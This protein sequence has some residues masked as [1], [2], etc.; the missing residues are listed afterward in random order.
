MD[1]TWAADGAAHAGAARLRRERRRRAYLRYARMSVA[2]ALAEATHRTAPRCQKTARARGEERDELYDAKG[3]M[4]PPP[5]RPT[6]LVEVRPQGR[7]QR[8]FLE[9]MAD[10]CPYVQILDA[11]VPPMVENVTVTLRIMNFPIAEQDIDVPKISCSP[12]PSRSRVPEPQSAD[13]LMEVPTVLSPLHPYANGCSRTAAG[14]TAG[15]SAN[16]PVLS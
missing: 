7:V 14:G 9:H 11:P 15:G 10:I 13:Q 1:F 2:M 16:Y 12:C 3:L 4:T 8:H 5:S 6:P